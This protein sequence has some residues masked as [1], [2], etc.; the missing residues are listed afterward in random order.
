MYCKKCGRKMKDGKTYCEYCGQGKD[1]KVLTGDKKK[2]AVAQTDYGSIGAMCIIMS[3]F[4]PVIGLVMSIIYL[5]TMH[6][7]KTTGNKEL[8][9]K[10]F[11]ISIIIA[12]SWSVIPILIGLLSLIGMALKIKG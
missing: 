12:A 6:R 9:K 5:S 4:F 2:D 8:G 3:I 7:N 10:R 1:D 11:I